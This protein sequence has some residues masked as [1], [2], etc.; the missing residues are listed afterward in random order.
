MQ[1]MNHKLNH[2]LVCLFKG[3]A[4]D[5]HYI[6]YIKEMKEAEEYQGFF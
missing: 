6:T 4:D 3:K 2:T 5:R 1:W